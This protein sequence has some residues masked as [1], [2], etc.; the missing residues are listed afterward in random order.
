MRRPAIALLA[1]ILAVG[2][3]GDDDTATTTTTIPTTSTT[4]VATTDAP[5]TTAPPVTLPPTTSAPETTTTAAPTTTSGGPYVIDPGD[6]FPDVF[7][8]A[9]DAHGSGCVTGQDTLPDGVWF[10]FVTAASGANLSFDL[11]CFYTGAA[12]IAAATADGEVGYDLDF[13]IRNNNPKLY[14]VVLDLGG[15]AWYIST[16]SGG[17]EPLPVAASAWPVGAGYVPCPGDYCAVWL[18]VNGGIATG[19]VEQYLP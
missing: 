16:G 2:A 4:G 11:A 18:Y 1:V 17:V 7:P 12:G 8:G 5:T 15:T 19:L 9:A 3:C 13:Y 10:G 14:P 6:L